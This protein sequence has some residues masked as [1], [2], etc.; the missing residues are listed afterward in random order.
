VGAKGYSASNKAS[1]R[2]GDAKHAGNISC[3]DCIRAR[4]AAFSRARSEANVMC[5]TCQSPKDKDNRG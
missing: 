4:H 5:L 1:V 3:R 2:M